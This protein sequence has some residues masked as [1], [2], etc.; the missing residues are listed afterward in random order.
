MQ[1]GEKKWNS[2]KIQEIGL[3]KCKHVQAMSECDSYINPLT[4]HPTYPALDNTARTGQKKNANLK[5]KLDFSKLRMGGPGLGVGFW[6]PS[7]RPY[8]YFFQDHNSPSIWWGIRYISGG[9]LW[10]SVCTAWDLMEHL[11]LP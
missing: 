4:P 6:Q 2:S 11:G 3:T 10:Q 5:Q 9:F 7:P 1:I 8:Q